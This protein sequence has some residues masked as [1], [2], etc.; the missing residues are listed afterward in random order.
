M[1]HDLQV[2]FTLPTE[3]LKQIAANGFDLLPELIR[4]LVIAAMQQSVSNIS[5]LYLTNQRTSDKIMLMDINIVLNKTDPKSI[6][7]FILEMSLLGL[8]QC[9]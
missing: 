1:T 9:R 6:G 5:E 2:D 7:S 8:S 3:L 4:I